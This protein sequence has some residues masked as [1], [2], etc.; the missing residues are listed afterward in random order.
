MTRLRRA[1]AALLALTAIVAAATSAQAR[2]V[3]D[4]VLAS[5]IPGHLSRSGNAPSISR[6]LTAN[7]RFVFF[8]STATD[9]VTGFVDANGSAASDLFVFDRKSKK[10]SLALHDVTNRHG[11]LNAGFGLAAVSA[12][13]RFVLFSTAATDVIPGFVDH[14]GAGGDLYLL[15]RKRNRIQLISHAAGSLTATGNGSTLS[16]QLSPNTRYV[17]FD[18]FA[19]DLV[20]GFT[21]G[22]GAGKNDV[23]R[24]DRTTGATVLVSHSVVSPL[25]GGNDASSLSAVASDGTV[26]FL[27]DADDLVGGFVDNNAGSL[28]VFL[29]RAGAVSLVSHKAGSPSAGANDGSGIAGM[30]PTARLITIESPATDLL[31]GFVDGNGPSGDDVYLFDVRTGLLKLISHVPGSDVKSGNGFSTTGDFVGIGNRRGP[32]S[33]NFGSRS[34]DILTGFVD[35]NGPGGFDDFIYSIATGDVTLV[36]HD[37]ANPVKGANAGVFQPGISPSGRF[38]AFGTAATNLA[39]LIDANGPSNADALRLDRS[40]G[41]WLLMSHHFGRALETGSVSSFGV[42][43]HS[44]S[45]KGTVAFSSGSPDLVRSFVDGNATGF[46]FGDAYVSR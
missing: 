32:G 24:F 35:Q 25:Q 18:S 3:H 40:T 30:D 12:N 37:P 22:N 17:T 27:S 41:R 2:P 9:L 43:P 33:I 28:D 5:R 4:D 34:T 14:D 7:S 19:T 46:S 38:F 36:S 8:S 26:A 44:V 1:L 42:G 10:V 39:P 29:Y 16:A 21:D 15:D 31:A 45:D 20:P 23:F 13:G 11:G 6:L